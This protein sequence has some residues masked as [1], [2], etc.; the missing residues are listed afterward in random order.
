[1]C[2]RYRVFSPSQTV[3]AA[4]FTH[5]GDIT[6][7]LRLYIN[8]STGNTY[9]ERDQHHDITG[10]GRVP[11]VMVTPRLP[12]GHDPVPDEKFTQHPVKLPA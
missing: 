9:G 10:G 11:L 12:E 4:R 5:G 2:P 3:Y 1:M 6:H 7:R 8:S